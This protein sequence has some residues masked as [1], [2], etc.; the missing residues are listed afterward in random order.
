[1]V[2]MKTLWLNKPSLKIII[3]KR[4]DPEGA[5]KRS[6]DIIQSIEWKNKYLRG[7]IILMHPVK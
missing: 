2:I 7:V 6:H 5:N 4:A 3:H 1:M